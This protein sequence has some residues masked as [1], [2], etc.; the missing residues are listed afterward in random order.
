MKFIS[1]EIENYRQFYGVQRLEFVG[2]RDKNVTMIFGANGSGKT[3]LL[4]AFTWCLFGQMPPGLESP[5]RLVNERAFGE[6]PDGV[7]IYARV[8][9]Q[10]IHDDLT[11]TVERTQVVR[12]HSG[13]RIIDRDGGPHDVTVSLKRPSGETDTTVVNPNDKIQQILPLE[14]HRSF[15][16]DGE[17]MEK[18]VKSSSS[19]EIN[20][21]IKKILG[22]E[23]IERSIVHLKAAEKQLRKEHTQALPDGIQREVEFIQKEIDSR[24]DSLEQIHD[25]LDQEESNHGALSDEIEA[26]T[27]A[28]RRNE[29]SRSLQQ[30]R[31]AILA[32]ISSIKE[33]E[34]AAKERQKSAITRNGFL[35]FTGPL[36]DRVALRVDEIRER[37]QIP[38]PIKR[39]F[40]EDLLEKGQC[41]CGALLT[42]GSDCYKHVDEW[43]SRAVAAGAEE[44]W[45]RLGAQ[46]KQF[47]FD[48]EGLFATLRICIN[49]RATLSRNYQELRD[50]LSEI[51]ALLGNATSEEIQQLEGNHA[52]LQARLD[53]TNQKIGGLKRDIDRITREVRDLEKARKEKTA[54]HG[55]A[56]VAAKRVEGASEALSFFEQ[57]LEIK[58]DDTR[59]DLDDK[60]KKIYRKISYKEYVPE[61]TR[62][63]ELELHKIVNGVKTP[64]AKSTG[65]NQILSLSFV[66]AIADYA[67][68][69]HEESK[70]QTLS[71]FEGGIFPIVMDS[72]FGA[73]DENYREQIAD[74][75]PKLGEQIIVLVSKSQG[76]GIVL[77]KLR[78]RLC[79][80]YVIEY[81]TPKLGSPVETIDLDGQLFS[82]VSPSKTSSEWAQLRE[83]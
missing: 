10:F 39:Q 31:D 48:R 1:M 30:E 44:N 25:E 16:F 77:E 14:L 51:E 56:Q 17:R 62:S 54:Q 3:T 21:A 67:R 83:V 38:T 37:G 68:Q 75:I 11:Y 13:S 64:V 2:S 70:T 42:P 40:V 6:T 19:K 82:Y 55:Q 27:E 32:Q 69:L 76:L 65:E 22:L 18:L 66:G 8:T 15:F 20:A 58:T 7:P 71:T 41:I 53:A 80:R 78:P 50:R 28:L 72:P 59:K 47:G 34:L 45:A 60:I 52:M 73:L 63:F 46:A 5:D 26:V 33:Q 36:T 9:I 24:T 43:R 35:A 12:K 4:S 29:Q 81:Q 49:E 23:L 74:A 57:L 61:L 79:R